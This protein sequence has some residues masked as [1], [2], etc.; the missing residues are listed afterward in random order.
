MPSGSLLHAASKRGLRSSTSATGVRFQNRLLRN[1]SETEDVESA[2]LTR[3]KLERY[4]FTH[5]T[6][7][8]LDVEYAGAPFVVFASDSFRRAVMKAEVGR[9]SSKGLTLDGSCGRLYLS[10]ISS[11]ESLWTV[12]SS[13]TRSCGIYQSFFEAWLPEAVE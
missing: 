7:A 8:L 10:I 4:S 2:Q 3:Y 6:N 12:A 9:S 11:T 1:S 13:F 5:S